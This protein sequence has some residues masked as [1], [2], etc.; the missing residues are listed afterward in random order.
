MSGGRPVAY[1]VVCSEARIQ[2]GG[3]DEKDNLVVCL[4]ALLAAPA[5]AQIKTSPLFIIE[6]NMNAN[7]VHYDARFIADGNWIPRNR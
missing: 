6:R 3:P 1:G 5:A 4:L 2:E 7:V